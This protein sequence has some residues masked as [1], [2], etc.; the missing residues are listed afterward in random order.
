MAIR[1]AIKSVSN[2]AKKKSASAPRYAPRSPIDS[3]K[4]G[5]LNKSIGPPKVNNPQQKENALK[6]TMNRSQPRAAEEVA[7]R[8]QVSNKQ[9]KRATKRSDSPSK[10]PTREKSSINEPLDHGP[11][12]I[13]GPQTASSTGGNT[14]S[15]TGSSVRGEH[16]LN[17]PSKNMIGSIGATAKTVFNSGKAHF[18]Q[19]GTIGT[20]GKGIAKSMGA[21]AAISGG[22]AAVQG[23]DIWDAA[24]SGAVRGAAM[25]AGYMGAKGAMGTTAKFGKGGMK[26][27]AR[28]MNQAYKSTTV[29][30][31]QAMRSGQSP[32]SNQLK[33]VL[34]NN[35]MSDFASQTM[36]HQR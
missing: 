36:G 23:D 19:P 20:A 34:E 2:L 33:K 29:A 21:N 35:R 9:S 10:T 4:A 12:P 31:Q 5:Q 30:G 14:G 7:S 16:L 22:L 3:R 6:K 17:E 18:S 26:D 11:Q 15:S 28:T 13:Y 1:N 32:M 8:P 25:G 24:K 27:T